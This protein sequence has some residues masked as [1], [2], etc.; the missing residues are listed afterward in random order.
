MCKS[1]LSTSQRNDSSALFGALSIRAPLKGGMQV[2]AVVTQFKENQ[3]PARLVRQFTRPSVCNAI[4]TGLLA[5]GWSM[6]AAFPPCGSGLWLHLAGYSCGDSFSW[7]STVMVQST[8]LNSLVALSGSRWQA[9]CS[10][11]VA[12]PSK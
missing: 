9:L 12:T 2:A 5:P 6:T 4:A 1:G 3:G 7:Q 10:F 8:A 11:G